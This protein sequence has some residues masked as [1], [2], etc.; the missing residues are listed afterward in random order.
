MSTPTL[1]ATSELVAI[2]WLKGIVGDIVATTLP[3]PGPNGPTWADTGFCALTI[4][5]G[6]TN[7]YV[8]VRRPLVAIDC[9]A[10]NPD[11]QKPPWRHANQLA[12]QIQAGCYDVQ[13]IPRLLVLGGG[14]PAA[15]VLSAYTAYEARRVPDDP[16]S[17]ARYTLGLTLHW[18]EQPV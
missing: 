18:T 17:Y 6:D 1:H 5:G 10:V 14:Y 8:P 7:M 9:W 2:T 16:S 11:S 3:K 15:R 12:E 13:D 4:V